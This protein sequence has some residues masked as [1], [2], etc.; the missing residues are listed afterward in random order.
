[1]TQGTL[2]PNLSEVK[3]ICLRPK[4]GAIQMDLQVCRTSSSCPVCGTSSDRVH[5]RYSRHLGDLPWER[6][7]V[8]ILLSTRKFFCTGRGCRRRIF[9]EPLPGVATRYARRTLRATEALNWITLAL[10]GQAGA[11]LARRLG[12]LASGSTL[13]RQVRRRPQR[14]MTSAPRVLGIDDWAWR[15]RHRYGTIL[16]DLEAGKVID[17]LPDRESETVA[18]WLREHPGTQIVSRDRASTYAEAA[19]K[20]APGT[21]QIAD[22]W[23]LLSNLS[24]ALRTAL[25]PH[26]SVMTQAARACRALD[27]EERLTTAQI[28]ATPNLTAKEKNRE[29]RQRLYEQVKTLLDSGVSQSDV[30][31]QLDISLRSIQ[32]WIQAGA[33]PERTPRRYPHSVDAY[34]GY[35]DK[36]LLQGCHNVSQ[37][38]RELRQQGYRGQLS[39]VWNWLPE[40]SSK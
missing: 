4:D 20:A 29:R 8:R 37:L 15:K 36:R 31:R 35:L 1:M 39:S 24:D 34:A 11:R 9:T 21:I 38:W 30:A 19:R 25:E 13:L 40:A 5:S 18:A 16:C 6:L 3:L 33:F 7:P 10:G 2:L 27:L 22:R 28:A 26:R 32:R 23:H 14:T 17:L 12:L